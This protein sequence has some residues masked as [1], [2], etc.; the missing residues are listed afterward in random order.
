MLAGL[1]ASVGVA[2]LCHQRLGGMQ[3][4]EMAETVL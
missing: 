4:D 2:K 1:I 3:L